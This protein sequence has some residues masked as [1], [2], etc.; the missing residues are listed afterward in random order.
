MS[1]ILMLVREGERRAWRHTVKHSVCRIKPLHMFK[2]YSSYIAPRIHSPMSMCINWS[3]HQTLLCRGSD[4]ETIQ[5]VAKTT[6][7]HK[8]KISQFEITADQSKLSVKLN[9]NFT[10]GMS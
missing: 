5:T 6:I 8:Q 9:A 7:E 10:L 2:H 1:S 4:T 3:Q